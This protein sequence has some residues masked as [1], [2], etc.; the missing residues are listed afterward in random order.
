VSVEI[1][2]EC[3]L[4]LAWALEYEVPL[5]YGFVW[6]AKL[7]EGEQAM[8]I[9]LRCRLKDEAIVEEMEMKRLLV[10]PEYPLA[11]WEGRDVGVLGWQNT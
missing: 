11:S 1:A 2:I 5:L 8:Q 9:V 7:R 3:N 10:G 6:H 4:S